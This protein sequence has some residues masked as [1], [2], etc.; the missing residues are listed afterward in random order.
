MERFAEIGVGAG[1]AIAIAKP[2]P[3]TG[4]PRW[5]RCA[6]LTYCWK[7]ELRLFNGS[8]R[9]ASPY[10]M[11]LFLTGTYINAH[12]FHNCNVDALSG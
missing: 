11:V 6:K 2:S 3:D 1:Q 5:H 12:D 10:D 4:P 7:K 9:I 8:H